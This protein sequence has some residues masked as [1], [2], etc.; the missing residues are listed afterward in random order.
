MIDGRLRD[1]AQHAIG[2]VGRTGDLEEVAPA[3]HGKQLTTKHEGHEGHEGL[4]K[5]TG[6]TTQQSRTE[7]HVRGSADGPLRR[8]TCVVETDENT[9]GPSLSRFVFR[10]SPPTPPF[11]GARRTESPRTPV[12]APLVSVP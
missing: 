3:L 10:L 7:E 8:P 9:P 1:R 4:R 12:H 5:F 2:H 11:R 6:E